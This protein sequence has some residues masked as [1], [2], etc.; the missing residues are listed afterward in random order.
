LSIVNITDEAVK[1][2]K[3]ML[4]E[5]GLPPANLRIAGRIDMDGDKMGEGYQLFL[6]ELTL[7]DQYQEF[8]D[9][10]IIVANILLRIN[11]GFNVS[12]IEEN[13]K[14]RIQILPFQ[15]KPSGIYRGAALG[16]AAGQ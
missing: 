2:I 11:G 3:M 7:N 4:A 6:S 9:F 15:S 14:T 1:E 10:N 5:E 16:T 12:C 13:G 8:D